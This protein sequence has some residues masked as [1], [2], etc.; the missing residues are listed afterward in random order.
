M[1]GRD[2]PQE[3]GNPVTFLFVVLLLKKKVRKV[4]LP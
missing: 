4:K 2:T 1:S 3:E